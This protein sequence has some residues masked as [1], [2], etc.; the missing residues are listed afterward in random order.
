M[1]VVN[2]E[3]GI[4]RVIGENAYML[5]GVIFFVIMAVMMYRVAIKKSPDDIHIDV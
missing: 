4:S 1:E 2:F 3:H 5:L